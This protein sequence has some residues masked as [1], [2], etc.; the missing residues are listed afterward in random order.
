MKIGLRINEQF[1]VSK[2]NIALV[3]AFDQCF[4]IAL[5]SQDFITVIREEHYH[6]SYL[7]EHPYA[8]VS[9]NEYYRIQRELTEY[10]GIEIKDDDNK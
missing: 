8:V 4:T 5:S 7:S 6:P 10:F 9:V 1:T 3:T 2:P